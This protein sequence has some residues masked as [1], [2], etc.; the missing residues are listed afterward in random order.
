MKVAI[1]GSRGFTD[2]NL[3]FSTLDNL[4]SID[5]D[6]S[7]INEIVTGGAVGTDQLAEEY[8]KEMS[9]RTEIY[10][11]EYNRYGRGA[12]LKRNLQIIM[13]CDL[14]VAFWDGISP[15]THYSIREATKRNKRVVIINI[16]KN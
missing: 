9:I 15:G 12:P 2:R 10:L 11:P 13:A 4:T 1:I 16:N 6:F 5:P 7:E 8:A 3:L 14:M